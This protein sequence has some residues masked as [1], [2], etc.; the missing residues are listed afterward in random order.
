MN[1]LEILISGTVG[2]IVT[3]TFPYYAPYLIQFKMN[4]IAKKSEKKYFGRVL[5]DEER[6]QDTYQNNENF[7]HFYVAELDKGGIKLE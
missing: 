2:L 7:F 4:R 5:T 1:E 6:K 3:A